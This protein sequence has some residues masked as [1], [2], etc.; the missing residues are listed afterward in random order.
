MIPFLNLHTINAR[1]E[2]QFKSELSSFFDKGWYV[3]GEQVAQFERRFAEL[4]KDNYALGVGNGLDALTLIFKGY[5]TLGL[6]NKGDE[7]LVPANTYIASILALVEV[8]LTPVLVEPNPQ[9]YNI[10]T[11]TILSKITARTKAILVVHLY[12]QLVDMEIIE[13]L[14]NDLSLLIVEDCAQSHGINACSNFTKAFSFYP[15]KNLGAL[16]DGGA[17]VTNEEDLFK[18]V[19]QLRNYGSIEKYRHELRGVNSRLDEIQ[20]LFL[21]VKLPFLHEDNKNRRRIAQRY[22]NEIRNPMIQLPF[23]ADI[24]KH[25]FHLFVIQTD[26]RNDL[27]AYLLGQ[28]IETQIHYPI[29][30]HQQEAFSE[31]STFSFPVTE[32]I[33]QRVLSLPMSPVLTDEEVTKIISVINAY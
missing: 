15:S 20:A 10:S 32:A 3:L 31:W 25:V 30:P 7:V 19:T 18:V 17:I 24:E 5:I 28:Q 21:N 16:G 12:G 22:L 14:A 27:Q 1:F 2:S 13:K 8:G 29:P 6:L 11:E 33:H 9:T 26:N 4:N 23:V